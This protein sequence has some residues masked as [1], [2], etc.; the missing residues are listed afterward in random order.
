[1]LWFVL[2][3]PAFLDLFDRFLVRLTEGSPT[4]TAL[5][6]HPP[7]ETGPPKMLRMRVYRYRFTTPEERAETGDW[8]H[9]TDLGP[10]YPLPVVERP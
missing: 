6:A 10:F 9:R 1:M 5:I 4:V 7:L 3:N 8:W 2:M